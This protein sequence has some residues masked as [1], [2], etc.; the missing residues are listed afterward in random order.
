MTKK[1][2]VAKKTKKQ[3][4]TKKLSELKHQFQ[5]KITFEAAVDVQTCVLNAL[6]LSK[7]AL[8]ESFDKVWPFT[9]EDP[10]DHIDRVCGLEGARCYTK[11]PRQIAQL[12]GKVATLRQFIAKV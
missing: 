11:T 9:Q 8:D 10:I 5:N 4:K 6:H 3:L 2:K 12:R 1:R 7:D